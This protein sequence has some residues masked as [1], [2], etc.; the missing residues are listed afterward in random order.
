MNIY[1]KDDGFKQFTLEEANKVLPDIIRLTSQILDELD[2]VR[3]NLESLHEAESP[4]FAGAFDEYSADI[5][6]KWSQ[7]VVKFGA[8]PK[9]FFTVDFKSHIPDTLLCWTYGE[10][11]IS[12]THK[13]YET[14][15]RR[16][17]ITD[18]AKIGFEESVN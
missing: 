13:T 5:L 1:D 3:E 7:T 4:E 17:P 15:K 2:T 8:Y 11:Q 18:P 12:H 6:A 10:D 14:F 16:V 9:G